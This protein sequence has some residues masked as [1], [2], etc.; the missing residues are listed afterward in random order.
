MS[1]EEAARICN[2]P[3]NTMKSRVKRARTSLA[4]LIGFDLAREAQAAAED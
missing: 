3:V 1:Y 2:C 4:E